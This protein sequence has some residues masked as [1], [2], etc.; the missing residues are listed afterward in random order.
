MPF[1]LF[2]SLS[3]S[4]ISVLQFS[5]NRSFTSLV[6]FIPRYLMAFGVIVNRID[7]LTSLSAASL[8]VYSNA[9]D[10]Y[11][12]ILYPRTLLN[13][14]ISSSNFLVVFPVFY[15]GYHIICKSWWFYFFLAGLDAFHFCSLVWLLWLGLPVLWWM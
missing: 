4:F 8:L 14:H 13:S 12:L 3:I 6:R 1:H 11:T 5:E 15:T 9:T 7:S 10:F 2:V